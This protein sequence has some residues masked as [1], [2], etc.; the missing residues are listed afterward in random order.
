[1]KQ[2]DNYLAGSLEKIRI[3]EG[4]QKA[5]ESGGE[6]QEQN[7]KKKGVSKKSRK[8]ELTFEAAS[9][10]KEIAGTD[11]TQVEG[12]DVKTI[13]VV[14]SV[15]GINMSKWRSAEAFA[16]WLCLSPRPKISNG[17]LKGY[18]RRKTTNPAT[19]ALRIAA[20]ALHSSKSRLGQLYRRVY[21]KKGPKAAIKCVARHL[22]VLI[23]TLIKKQVEYDDAFYQKD[24]ERQQ[25]KD[26]AKLHKLAKMY[27]YEVVK[28]A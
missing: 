12:L 8:N 1:M 27:G 6:E 4:Q 26:E 3:I 18:E 7:Q 17:K 20:R 9:T 25:K 10:L 24:R 11:L 23:Y 13:L 14:L 15:T 21:I 2:Y 16:S 22:A 28:I 5:M 19:Q